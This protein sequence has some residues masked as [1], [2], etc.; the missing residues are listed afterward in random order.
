[1]RLSCDKLKQERIL[2]QHVN[3]IILR[4]DAMNCCN[5]PCNI[6]MYN[7]S[8]LIICQILSICQT[9]RRWKR[10]KERTLIN[11]IFKIKPMKFIFSSVLM[12]WPGV[13]LQERCVPPTYRAMQWGRWVSR[14]KRWG[15]MR[16]VET[17]ANTYMWQMLCRYYFLSFY[18]TVAWYNE[19]IQHRT[20]GHFNEPC[21]QC[22]ENLQK[23]D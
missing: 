10:I 17:I 23:C 18:S 5:F 2:S 15:R 8:R 12:W 14:W 22:I 16:Y 7:L 4:L 1:M 21:L 6:C 11:Y 9:E 19:K 13:P 3:A 20:D